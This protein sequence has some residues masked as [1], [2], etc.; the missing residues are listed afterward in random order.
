MH[1]QEKAKPA[2]ESIRMIKTLNEVLEN[3]FGFRSG[4]AL[5]WICFVPFCTFRAAVFVFVAGYEDF[6]CLFLPLNWSAVVFVAER[7]LRKRIV[8]DS[9]RLL[10]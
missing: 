2:K 5:K 1:D 3:R 4:F 7:R 8:R 6:L 10:A 9:C